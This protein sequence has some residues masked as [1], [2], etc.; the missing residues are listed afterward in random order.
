M[1]GNQT[2][3]PDAPGPG[4]PLRVKAREFAGKLLTRALTRPGNLLEPAYVAAF[5][6]LVNGEV[7]RINRLAIGRAGYLGLMSLYPELQR[8]FFIH[9]PKCGGTSIRQSLVDEYRCAPVPMP[10][11]GATRQSIDYMRRSMPPDNPLR[12]SK[13]AG[14]GDPEQDPEQEFLRMFTAYRLA[15]VP[16]RIFIFGHKFAREM[17]PFYRQGRD[18]FFTTVRDPTESLSSMLAYR[19][20]H[21]LANRHRVD[22][23]AFLQSLQVEYPEFEELVAGNP[24]GLTELALKKTMPSLSAFLSMND[25]T[26][27]ESVWSGLREHSVFIAHMSEQSAM[28]EKLFGSRPKKRR[29]N[30]S[31]SRQGIAADFSSRLRSDWIA[32]HVDPESRLLYERL[33]SA[34]VIG[35]W[36]TGGTMRQYQE[37]LKNG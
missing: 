3:S 24:E 32:P 21:T 5:G 25:Q 8:T 4:V 36:K 17:M 15:R 13:V 28:L 23:V 16:E 35:F 20:S 7:A 11:E 12:Q 37:I 19:V 6:S 26:D 2:S 34:G 31:Q 27:C 30:S 29:K 33:E 14:Q 1:S 9:I 22:S 10:T 18:I